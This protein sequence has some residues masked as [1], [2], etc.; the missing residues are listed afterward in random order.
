MISRLYTVFD[1]D[2]TLYL[3]RDYVRSGFQVVGH[4]VSQ[5]LGIHDF[6]ERCWSHFTGGQSGTIFDDTLR[7]CGVEFN[8]RIVT[9]LVELYRAHTPA[10]FLAEDVVATLD[11]IS[12]LAPMAI[13]SDG[14][15]ASQSRKAE[16]L[17]LSNFA[18]PILLTD[19]LGS[20]FHKP[21]LRAFEELERLC[22]AAA[23][24]YIADNPLKDFVAPKHLG[25]RTVRIRRPKGLHF[26]VESPDVRPDFEMTDFLQLPG[27]LRDL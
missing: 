6:A 11:A 4:W 13:I 18:F 8:P 23:Y 20:A 16:S 10:I 9:S 17:G 7:E 24:V 3:E 22:P 19:I 12:A 21:H 2:D 5:W 14:P 25:W 1:I 27:L 26:S 15:A